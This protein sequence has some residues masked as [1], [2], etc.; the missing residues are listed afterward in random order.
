MEIYGIIMEINP[1][2]NGHLY[3]LKE[4]KA[5]AKDNPLVCIISTNIVQRGEISVL[6][7]DIKTNLLLDN[8]VD[9]VC[10]LPAVLAN[11]GGEYFALNAVKILSKFNVNNLI[12]GSE[13]ADL[14]NLLAQIHGTTAN[15]SSFET[16][17][18]TNLKQLKSNDILGISYIKAANQLDLN[19]DYHLVQ[20][21]SNNYNDLNIQS[22]IASA[23]SIRNNLDNL[24]AVKDTLPATSLDNILHVDDTLLFNLFKVNLFNAIDNQQLIFLSEDNQLLFR[25]QQMIVKYNPTSLEQLLELCKDKNNSKFKYSRIAINTILM[26]TKD[27]YDPYDYIRVLG[28][29]PKFSKLL[30]TDSFTSLASVDNHISRIEKRAAQLFS[31]LTNNF[32]YDEFN[33]KPLI[34]KEKNGF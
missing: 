22:N 10:E 19:L 4:A 12:F 17:I 7:K 1:F 32:Q 33:R 9:I 30:P 23:T 27:Q 24:E 2:H 28:F 18:H 20:R 29:N 16:G 13:S 26:I 8:G 25:M 15:T 11:Q 21:I 34:Y 5:I 6:S 31:L 3:F 14:N